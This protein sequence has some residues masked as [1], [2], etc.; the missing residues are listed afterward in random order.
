MNSLCGATHPLQVARIHGCGCRAV[1]C[2]SGCAAVGAATLV[3]IVVVRGV[4]VTPLRRCK[5]E[6]WGKRLMGRCE[7][8][9]RT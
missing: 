5:G 3:L 7:G 6:G 4:R 1:W 2:E 8:D 9:M